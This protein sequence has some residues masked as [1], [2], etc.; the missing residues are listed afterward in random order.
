M[1]KTAKSFAIMLGSCALGL[2]PTSATGQFNNPPTVGNNSFSIKACAEKTIDL[3]SNDSDPEGNYPL[4]VTS[5]GQTSLGVFDIVSDS[6][7][8]FYASGTA[9]GDTVSYTVE[10]SLGAS[11]TGLINFGVFARVCP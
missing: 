8:I 11:A 5:V 3:T 1:L 10:D 4:R 9:G 7:V 6:S 2:V